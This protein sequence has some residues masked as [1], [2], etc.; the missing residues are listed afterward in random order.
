MQKASFLLKF[1]D[2]IVSTNH[3]LMR[4]TEATN[5]EIT[6]E[7]LIEKV[8]QSVKVSLEEVLNLGYRPK[9]NTRL[10]NGEKSLYYFDESEDN[11]VIYV[12]T[13]DKINGKTL[14]LATVLCQ[15]CETVARKIYVKNQAKDRSIVNVEVEVIN[16]W[17]PIDF[18]EKVYFKNNVFKIYKDK[19]KYYLFAK[20]NHD[21]GYIACNKN[22]KWKFNSLEEMTYFVENTLMNGI[23]VIKKETNIQI[24]NEKIS[25]ISLERKYYQ[26]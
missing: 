5:R 2:E 3:S 19:K 10:R 25:L 15:N 9:Y 1:Y 23:K 16:N 13:E 26:K 18:F 7:E 8:K 20:I 4:Y 17:Q 6:G 12:L 22:G 24:M 11:D 21:I 14:I